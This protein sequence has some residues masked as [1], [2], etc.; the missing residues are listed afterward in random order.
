M[1][2]VLTE[3][4]SKIDIV[5]LV[6]SYVSLKKAGRN[7]R[8]N[9]PFHSEKTPSFMVSPELQIFKCFGC[10][11]GGDIF[12]FLMK[13]EGLEFSAA[14]KMLA[15]RAGVK[16]KAPSGSGLDSRKE[17]LYQINHLAAEFFHFL[18]TAH[19]IG[20]RARQYL[21]DRGV[22]TAT[23]K[24]FLLGYAPSS[25]RSLSS[26]LVKKGFSPSEIIEAGLALPRKGSGGD[27]PLYDRF[28]CRLMFP[29]RDSLGRV[30]GFSG[31]ALGAGEPKYLNSP[32]TPIFKKGSFLYG[33]D[34]TKQEIKKSGESLIVEGQFDLILPYQEGFRAIV[35]SLGTALTEQQLTLL[36]RFTKKATLAFD[37]DA[38]GSE[39]AVRSV[40][41]AENLGFT[42]SALTLPEAVKDPDEAVRQ[43][44]DEFARA[45]AESQPFYDY[46]LVRLTKDLKKSDI[47]EKRNAAEKFLSQLSNLESPLIR[48]HYLKEL[49]KV[50]DME[51]GALS[52]VLDSLRAKERVIRDRRPLLEVLSA[53]NYSQDRIELLQKYLLSLL[54]GS[55][56]PVSKETL[57]KLLLEDFIS[58]PLRTIFSTVKKSFSGKKGTVDAKTIRDK[59]DEDCLP[60]FDEVYLLGASQALAEEDDS[61]AEVEF[62]L[63][64]LRREVLKKEMGE[65]SVKIKEA[66]KSRDFKE[67]EVLQ[68]ELQKT[69][70]KLN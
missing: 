44:K 23:A 9:C 30:L 67:V 70:E 29:L 50:L 51:V 46:Y 43:K 39:A 27:L 2:E 52:E 5:D 22:Q 63:S 31:R 56:V 59:L 16:L 53:T 68:H 6:S 36:S 24:T 10:Q 4:K 33:I 49:A 3:I 17:K 8:A 1:D 57:A 40:R 65:I 26:F 47:R 41:I 32:E 34:V 69:A 54:V 48:S 45:V 21:D 28:R 25:W 37:Q 62:A 66:E 18:L 58:A 13:V 11:E 61:T 60:L 12:S 19:K 14:L 15:E 55:S 38:A 42:V 64:Q 20:T 7:Y 35:A